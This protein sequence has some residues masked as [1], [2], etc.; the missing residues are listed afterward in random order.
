MLLGVDDALGRRLIDAG[1]KLRIYVPFGD[2]WYAYCIRR[3]KENPKIGR[4]VL[5]GMFK[6]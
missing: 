1:H 3:L 5:Q 6:R 2:Q 4:Y